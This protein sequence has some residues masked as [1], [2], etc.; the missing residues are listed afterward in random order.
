MLTICVLH[1]IICKRLQNTYQNVSAYS[2]KKQSSKN[3]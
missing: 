2:M 1:N 3:N